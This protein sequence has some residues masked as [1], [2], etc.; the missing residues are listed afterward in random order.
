ME[1]TQKIL[2]GDAL[3]AS[4]LT[5]GTISEKIW[6]IQKNICA[7]LFIVAL[8]AVV[9]IWKLTGGH[10]WIKKLWYI[11]TT[12][13]YVAIKKKEILLFVTAWM[14]LQSIVPSEISQSEKDKYCV[15]SLMW[16]L[17]NKIN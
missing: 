7:P 11:Y 9:K 8:F 12:E 14:D 6:N 3:W 1:L 15:I 10:Q 4:D 2:N 16:N 13:Y 5:S 17:I